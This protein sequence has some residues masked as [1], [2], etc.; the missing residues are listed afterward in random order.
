MNPSLPP[1]SGRCSATT[2]AGAPCKNNAASGSDNC[3]VHAAPLPGV[4]YVLEND[5]FK[6]LVKIGYT[7]RSAE[8]RAAELSTTSV[9]TPFRVA[10]ESRRV[11]DVKGVERRVHDKLR[12]VRVSGRREFFRCTVERARECVVEEVGE[13]PAGDEGER[14]MVVTVPAGIEELVLRFGGLA[15]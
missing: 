7:C 12:N 9:P 15:S 6:G 13:A 11:D 14:R 3:R 1:T 2:A 4:V 10:Y 8:Q 5:S